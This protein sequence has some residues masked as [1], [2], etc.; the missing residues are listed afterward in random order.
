[1]DR[2]CVVAARSGSKGLP[3]KNV[4]TF[5][6]KP[7][8][9]HS[10][11]QALATSIFSAIA[12]SSDCPEYLDIAR[13]AGADILIERP[14][15]LAGDAVAKLPVLRHALEFAESRCA[16][17]FDVLVDL[18][19]TSPLRRVEDITGAISHLEAHPEFLN[20]V[21]VSPSKASPYFTIVEPRADGTI[22]LSK[23]SSAERRQDVPEVFQLN[24]SIY[25]WRRQALFDCNH[26]LT[27]RTGYWNVPIEYAFDIDTELDFAL[28]A[29]VAE[30]Y[31]G[32]PA[33]P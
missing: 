23:E 17:R 3:G 10:V 1:M 15:A 27:E 25:S 11:E 21:S 26:T 2:I 12:V 30:T 33:T 13:L 24:G 8:L 7:L 6:G 18:Q 9:A 4:R 32:W 29:F 31:L 20:V 19:P 5:A 16:T 28:A 22:H 14:S